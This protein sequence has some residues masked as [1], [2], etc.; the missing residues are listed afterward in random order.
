MCR[1]FAGISYFTVLTWF[2][3]LYEVRRRF[4]Q[5]V[6]AG[7]WSVNRDPNRNYTVEGT[8]E[9]GRAVMLK[10]NALQVYDAELARLAR[11]EERLERLMQGMGEIRNLI[12]KA[13]LMIIIG[14]TA[15][16]ALQI[17]LRWIRF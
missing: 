5:H 16:I 11:F 2:S 14:F 4:I 17:L 10:A 7:R 9:G 12:R 15:L 8:I 13:K 6:G 1:R 3:R